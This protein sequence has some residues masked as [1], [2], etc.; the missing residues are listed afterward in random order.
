MPKIGDTDQTDLQGFAS[1]QAPARELG[2]GNPVSRS[3]SFAIWVPKP[4][5]GNPRKFR[6]SPFALNLTYKP[7]TFHPT[8]MN[9]G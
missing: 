1:S 6:P 3:W 7:Y 4:E 2:A 5:L 9:S 8:P